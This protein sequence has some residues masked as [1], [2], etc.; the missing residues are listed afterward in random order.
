MF[1]FDATSIA[2]GGTATVP[3]LEF[4][5]EVPETYNVFS[6]ALSSAELSIPLDLVSADF[7][8]KKPYFTIIFNTTDIEVPDLDA[9]HGLSCEIV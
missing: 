6:N 9:D 4:I 3:G 1:D 8:T 7:N 2:Y 5:P